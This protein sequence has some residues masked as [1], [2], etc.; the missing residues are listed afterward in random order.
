MTRF[1]HRGD[2]APST[3]GHVWRGLVITRNA[4]Y[5]KGVLE[6]LAER[7]RQAVA[8]RNRRELQRQ[9]RDECLSL[10]GSAHDARAA[11]V[12]EACRKSVMDSAPQS[13]S[14]CLA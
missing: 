11:V 1:L 10:G 12:I 6:P 9:F 5:L 4:A 2:L 7:S 13:Q 14:R 3:R 8:E